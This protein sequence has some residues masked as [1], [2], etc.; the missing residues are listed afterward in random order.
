MQL[1]ALTPADHMAVTRIFWSTCA[2]GAA[3][4][5]WPPAAAAYADL[6]LGWYLGPAAAT[7]AVAVDGQDRVVGY[8]LCSVDPQGARRWQR[9]AAAAWVGA[10]A[11]HVAAGASRW[12]REFLRRRLLDA[13]RAARARVP[14]PW[15]AE[16]HVNVEVGHRRQVG[17]L[18]LAHL[19]ATCAQRGVGGWCAEM[20]A[21]QGRRT[22]AVT[23]GGARVLARTPSATWTWLRGVPVE[24]VVLARDLAHATLRPL[25][26][27]HPGGTS[28]GTMPSTGRAA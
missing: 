9:R 2:A 8:A 10:A 26:A 16:V 23:A 3:L 17:R 19:D 25:A 22:R 18:L 12:Q 4:P 24:R 28:A 20:T 1:R 15:P 27:A 11:A 5:E 13:S 7:A 6:C 21:V 14:R